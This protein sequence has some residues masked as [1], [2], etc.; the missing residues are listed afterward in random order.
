MLGWS[1]WNEVFNGW[2]DDP[3]TAIATATEALQRAYEIDGT[4]PDTL[5]LLAFLHISLQNYDKAR[6][7]IDKAMALFVV[8]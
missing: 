1:Y 2:T 3:D 5:A 6:D 7:L 8:H 4:N